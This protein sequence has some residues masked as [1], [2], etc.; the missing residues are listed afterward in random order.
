MTT[1]HAVSAKRS[2]PSREAE[3][4]GTPEV[5]YKS[6]IH[7]N[8]SPT[9]VARQGVLCLTTMDR[10]EQNSVER[11]VGGETAARDLAAFIDIP[12]VLQMDR[13][14][15]C[16]ERVQIDGRFA[17]LHIENAEIERITRIT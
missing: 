1:L 3:V 17:F 13:R 10:D 2:S 9:N 16:D 4:E 5:C 8:H 14:K 7:G 6:T 11:A 12:G 15:R